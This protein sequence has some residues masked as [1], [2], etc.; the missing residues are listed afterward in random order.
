MTAF[1]TEAAKA[2][3]WKMVGT[4]KIGLSLREYLDQKARCGCGQDCCDNTLHMI[5]RTTGVHYVGY[6]SNGQLV[7]ETAAS[8][9]STGYDTPTPPCTYIYNI[10]DNKTGIAVDTA[11]TWHASTGATG[12]KI[13]IGTTSG[14]HQVCN[15]LDLGNVLTATAGTTVGIA[16]LTNLTEYFV[17]ITPYNESGDTSDCVEISFTTIAED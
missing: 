5:D 14:G 16:A 4:K 6:I 10:E 12:Y 7:W 1:N 11:F 8:Y 2:F 15:A 17:T 13:T 9:N 3:L